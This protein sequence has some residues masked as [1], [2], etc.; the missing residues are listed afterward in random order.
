MGGNFEK[1]LV[2]KDGYVIKHF[3]CT[4]LN[5]DIEKTLKESL[6]ESGTSF[7]MGKDRTPEIFSE[8][9]SVICS[10][11]ENAIYGNLSPINPNYKPSILV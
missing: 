8:E 10:E 11:I 2:D 3:A 7:G 6:I 9:F 5:Y 4:T 1:Y